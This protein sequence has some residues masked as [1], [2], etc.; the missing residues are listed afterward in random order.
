MDCATLRD[1]LM[2]A[3]VLGRKGRMSWLQKS[4][5]VSLN[6]CPAQ[7]FRFSTREPSRK[8]SDSFQ[9]GNILR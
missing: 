6:M 9:V 3:A 2:V 4:T 8:R 7:I 1:L 5:A